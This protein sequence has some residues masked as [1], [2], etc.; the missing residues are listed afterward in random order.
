MSA[1]TVIKSEGMATAERGEKRSRIHQGADLSTGHKLGL[2][3][4]F[5]QQ[6]LE[7]RANCTCRIHCFCKRWRSDE[8]G[9]YF[10]YV[11]WQWNLKLPA[12]SVSFSGGGGTGLAGTAEIAKGVGTIAITNPGSGYTSAPLISLTG[13]GGSGATATATTASGHV[14]TITINYQGS[15]YTSA[16]AVS[17]SGGGGTGA[18]ATAQLTGYVSYVW[19]TNNGS[20]YTSVPAITFSGGGGTGATAVAQIALPSAIQQIIV[21]VTRSTPGRPWSYVNYALSDYWRTS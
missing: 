19:I 7:W 16:P 4:A 13:G 5:R 12:P 15:G 18:A 20:G 21:T 9:H 10:C 8:W 11:W 1:Q 6:A 2:F 14:S 3:T 17:F